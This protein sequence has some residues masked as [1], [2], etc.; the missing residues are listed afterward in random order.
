MD[1]KPFIVRYKAG[2]DKRI[3]PGIHGSFATMEQA[4]GELEKCA[5]YWDSLKRQGKFFVGPA[6]CGITVD[7]GA[8]KRQKEEREVDQLPGSPEFGEDECAELSADAPVSAT[9]TTAKK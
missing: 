4:E 7:E 2:S 1:I 9:S 3:K 8:L 6:V 5:R